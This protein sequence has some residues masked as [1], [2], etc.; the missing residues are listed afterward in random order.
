[1]VDKK[2]IDYS[3]YLVTDTDLCPRED[4]LDT[5]LNAINGG[6]SLVQLREKDISSREFYNEALAIK[7][8]TD[9]KAVP[10][11]INDRLDIA[12][13][14]DAD[15]LHIGQTDLPASVARRILGNDKILGLS[16]SNVAEAE[17]AVLDGADYLGVG[18]VFPTTTKKDAHD[19]GVEMLKDVRKII[20]VPIVGI[21]GINVENLPQIYG[22]HIDGIS[23]ISA[24]MGKSDPYSASKQLKEMVK[25]L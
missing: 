25:N 3:L 19:V 15:G 14:I 6:V 4:L 5:V 24:I 9:A 20:K 13:A 1:M 2:N 17:K 18:A 11:I 7:K 23:V 16:A 8:I 12:L 22:T 10:L 21:G